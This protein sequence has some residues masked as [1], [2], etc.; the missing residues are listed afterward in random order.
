MDNEDYEK[1]VDSFV[2]RYQKKH[3]LEN[4]AV[5]SM[6]EAFS[7]QRRLNEVFVSE[8]YKWAARVLVAM[9]G[10]GLWHFI[11]ILISKAGGG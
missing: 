6:V 3:G 4:D 2:D 7:R 10:Y 9:L 5:S 11:G 1:M 8:L